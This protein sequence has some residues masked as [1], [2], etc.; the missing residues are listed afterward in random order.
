MSERNN[1]SR[2]EGGRQGGEGR[3]SHGHSGHGRDFEGKRGPRGG[4]DERGSR[5]DRRG[6]E[7]GDSRPD[8]RGGRDD[9]RR[10]GR[11][12][13]RDDDRRGGRDDDR[14]G[15][16][17]DDRRDNRRG[18]KRDD[19][20]QEEEKAR[21]HSPQRSGYREERINRRIAD[22]DL[23]DDIDIEDLDPSVLQDLRSLSKDNGEAVAKHM[24]MAATWMD[25][26]PKLAL[27]HARAAKDRAGR[28]SIAREVNGIAAYRAGEWKEALAELRAA[29]RISGGPGMLAVMADCERGLGR[30]EK[31]VELGRSEDASLL[32]R[33]SAI[34]LAIVVAGARLDM[35]QAESAVIT[36]QRAQPSR[37]D[38]GMSAC[39]LSYAYANALAEAGRVDEAKE[40]FEHTVAIN[41]G[42]WTDASER[43][44]EL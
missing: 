33:E 12:G 6:G 9:D 35:G 28:V 5:D 23:P 40:W 34:E 20:R 44:A 24:I 18:D 41:E 13:G 27:R 21:S 32:D 42:D 26:D 30:P 16:R 17:R 22:P 7:R 4:R 43:L 11:R 15:G 29:R 19:R 1:D 36:I 25:D 39:R 31:A 14:R 10:G 2:R 38:R 37:D 8:R 3:G